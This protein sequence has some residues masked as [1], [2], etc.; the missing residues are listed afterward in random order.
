MHHCYIN[1]LQRTVTL[2]RDTTV[3]T[4]RLAAMTSTR[5]FEFSADLMKASYGRPFFVCSDKSKPF[6]FWVWGNV[7]PI[8]KH[9]CRHGFHCVIRKVK[10]ESVNKDRLFFC[11]H[12]ENSCKYFEWV[13]EKTHYGPFHCSNFLD[14]KLPDNYLSEDF[15]NNFTKSLPKI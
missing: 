4:L 14:P 8:A 11:C 5:H 3:V 2:R 13:P 10:K 12:Q 1:P 7:K 6:S 9:K 15:I